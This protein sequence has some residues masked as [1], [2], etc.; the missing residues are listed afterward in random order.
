MLRLVFY[1]GILAF[2]VLATTGIGLM[3][4]YIDK[5]PVSLPANEQFDPQTGRRYTPDEMSDVLSKK[6]RAS[7]AFRL[8][9]AGALCFGSAFALFVIGSFI[10]FYIY[11]RY[12]MPG[13]RVEIPQVAPEP[14]P[15]ALLVTREPAPLSEPTP[16]GSIGITQVIPSKSTSPPPRHSPSTIAPQQQTSAPSPPASL[17]IH[18]LSPPQDQSSSV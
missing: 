8:S 3:S 18:E 12:C 1:L 4:S 14:V 10:L 17:Q 15:R 16:V 6:Q 13:D 9:I 11:P 5:I 7:E 2:I